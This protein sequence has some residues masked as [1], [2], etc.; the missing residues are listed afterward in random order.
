MRTR[1]LNQ[2]Q[3][4]KHVQNVMHEYTDKVKAAKNKCGEKYNPLEELADVLEMSF[5]F[6]LLERELFKGVKNDEQ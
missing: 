6:A 5:I 3:Y 4:K 1:L 2:V